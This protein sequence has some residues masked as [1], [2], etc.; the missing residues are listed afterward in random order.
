MSSDG[1]YL[2]QIDHD[3]V[4]KVWDLR[5]GRGLR[6]IPGQWVGA[7]FAPGGSLLLTS[8]AG[9]VTLIDLATASAK[10]TIF[11]TP[12]SSD[13]APSPWAFGPV[14]ASPDGKWVVAGSREGPLAALWPIAGGAPKRTV[15][16][17]E[18]PISAVAFASDSQRW[19]TAS[20]DGSA[21]IWGTDGDAPAWTLT[22]DPGNGEDD[23]PAVT[24]A[25]IG[26]GG[27]TRAA[28]GHRD[29]RVVLWTL[30]SGQ[31]AL[32][33]TIGKF[34]G[35]VH[36]IVFASDGSQLIAASA[37]KTIRLW[38]FDPN[39]PALAA[40]KRLV[41]QHTEQVNAVVAWP[42]GRM[43]ASAGD[44]GEIRFWRSDGSALLGTIAANAEDGTWVAYDPE[45]R[46]D[47]APGGEA[48]VTFL[49][50]GQVLGLDQFD[51][52]ARVF[53]LTT[54]WLDD[55]AAP[56]M[57]PYLAKRPAGLAIDPPIAAA[58]DRDAV[59]RVRLGD[60]D[61]SNLRLYQ[62]EVPVRDA[63]DF[64]ATDDPKVK[65]VEV[66][67]GAG[68]NRFVAMAARGEP[69]AVF[70]RS[71]P[72]ALN[73]PAAAE[74]LIHTLALG[75]SEYDANALK[76]ASD[77]AQAMTKFLER[78][79]FAADRAPGVTR[80][81][82]NDEVRLDV[83]E[84]ALREIRDRAQPEDTVVVFLAGHTD[85]RRDDRFCLLLDH[86][87][88]APGA[89]EPNQRG[90]IRAAKNASD[91]DIADTLLP[92]AAIYRTLARLN[93][94]NRLVVIDACQAGAIFDDPAV[95][96]IRRK[97]DDGAHQARTSYL[98]AARSGE[99]ANEASELKHGLL[100]YLMLAGMGADDLEA[101]P[102]EAFG[103]ADLDGDS[104]VT[105]EELRQY[106]DINLPILA[107]RVAAGLQRR[108]P[109]RRG[110]RPDTEAKAAKIEGGTAAFPVARVSKPS[111]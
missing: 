77:D 64:A 58:G 79:G 13:G 7:A 11:D 96:R 102:G 18:E 28:T 40:P 9:S 51:G 83:V 23:D 106:L 10:P 50:A 70:G 87:P 49:Q 14:A 5:E 91:A 39:R 34:D 43:F 103:T 36:S 57:S 44:D 78:N 98:L 25:A 107:A 92:Y 71:E 66:R 104:L 100:T 84:K 32:A 29:G 38:T 22:V 101:A 60:S 2:A 94:R 46:F 31:P 90:P 53:G 67:L 82:T 16:A 3:R 6:T 99:P 76:Y 59:L 73:G 56:G 86:F 15:K 72:V 97:A 75:I 35:A 17:H 54:F 27:L 19:L 26:P 68:E 63:E 48:R 20:L 42:G 45:G 52:N 21:K 61:A 41:P 110:P 93:A 88:F 95:A 24:A 62:N 109:Q 33:K 55:K 8:K 69:G 85:I 80:L 108:N 37:D 1:R 111:R 12:L 89:L 81:L 47:S 105:T 74:G 30:A 4:A 65:T